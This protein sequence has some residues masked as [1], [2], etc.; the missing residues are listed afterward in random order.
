MIPVEELKEFFPPSMF[1]G[2]TS[3]ANRVRNAISITGSKD[4]DKLFPYV[5]DGMYYLQR[6]DLQMRA[7]K[8]ELDFDTYIRKA[9][10]W[11]FLWDSLPD[12]SCFD[13]K[14]SSVMS[15]VYTYDKDTYKQL[16]GEFCTHD[17]AV[18]HLT[19]SQWELVYPLVPKAGR[20]VLSSEKLRHRMDGVLWVIR[21]GHRRNLPSCY[22]SLPVVASFLYKWKKTGVLT[23]ILEALLDDYCNGG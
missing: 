7:D 13:V 9:I 2:K 14:K 5:I 20:H 11:V 21:S 17:D 4:V 16:C 3:F 12:I 18:Y 22:G 1:D 15:D 6:R 23:A 10:E 8:S 19:D